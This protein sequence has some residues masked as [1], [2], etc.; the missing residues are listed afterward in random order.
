MQDKD[1]VAEYP[2][3]QADL[4][5]RCLDL[6][7]AL[8]RDAADL[9]KRGVTAQRIQKF[10]TDTAEFGDMEPDTV[11]KQEGAAV[12]QDKEAVR[13][14]LETTVQAV[15][16]IISLKDDVR[17]ARYKR[18]GVSD[19]S[20]VSDAKLHL[21]AT[22]L[23]KQGRKYL[24]EY[25]EQGLTAALLDDVD[26]QNAAFVDSLADRK[27]AESTRS[28]ATRARILFA[29][30]LYRQL[31]QLCAAGDSCWKLS[32]ATKA[33]EYVVDPT[34]AAAPVAPRAAVAG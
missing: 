12:T 24:E 9:A 10:K 5:Q 14:A 29:N 15:T 25:Q 3:T 32:D 26:T 11:L 7:I 18:F 16:S 13:V 17:S 2:F 21:A 20:S 8:D 28:G 33:G 27:E 6:H 4:W 1:P 23:V 31:V 34:P 22:M 19:V 30:G